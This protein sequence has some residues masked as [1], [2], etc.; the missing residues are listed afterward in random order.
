MPEFCTSSAG[1]YSMLSAAFLQDRIRCGVA[2]SGFAEDQNGVTASLADGS[3]I[4]GDV[5]IGAD[6]VRST[7]QQAA[8]LDSSRRLGQVPVIRKR[9]GERVKSTLLL[10]SES[11]S[12]KPAFAS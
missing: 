11:S 6:G 4:W 10:H 8:Y 12:T 5:L 9:I 3:E 7:V 1:L 2:L